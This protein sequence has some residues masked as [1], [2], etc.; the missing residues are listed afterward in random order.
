MFE[1]RLPLLMTFISLFHFKTVFD[2]FGNEYVLYESNPIHIIP[3]ITDHVQFEASENHVHVLEH[4]SRQEFASV[5]EFANDFMQLLLNSLLR[6]F[7]NK[8]FAVYLTVRLHDSMIIRFH[9]LW[10]D[11]PLFCNPDDFVFS[12]NEKVFMLRSDK[13]NR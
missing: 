6:C 9:Q 4:I 2:E 8:V 12:K 11:E 3:H 13:V 10:K 7:P 1:K 5:D